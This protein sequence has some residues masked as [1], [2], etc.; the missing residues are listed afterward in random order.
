M[1]V[2]FDP[3][4]ERQSSTRARGTSNAASREYLTPSKSSDTNA[5]PWLDRP[6]PPPSRSPERHS[7]GVAYQDRRREYPQD[8]GDSAKDVSGKT[9]QLAE[10]VKCQDD[11]NANNKDA[12]TSSS[13]PIVWDAG[14]Y[15]PSIDSSPLFPSSPDNDFASTGDDSLESRLHTVDTSSGT[16]QQSLPKHADGSIFSS[17]PRG[18]EPLPEGTVRE[19]PTVTRDNSLNTLQRNTPGEYGRSVSPT[20]ALQPWKPSYAADDDAKATAANMLDDSSAGLSGEHFLQRVSNSVKHARSLSDKTPRDHRLQRVPVNGSQA[21]SPRSETDRLREEVVWL[22]SELAT[23]RQR[24]KERDQRIAA[25]ETALNASADIKQANTELDEKRSTMVILD[26]QREIVL[27]ELGILSDHAGP[28]S[29]GRGERADSGV[30]DL[31]RITDPV[32]R[33]FADSIN[34]LEQSYAPQIEELVRKR[35]E[36]SEELANVNR[37]KDRSLREFDQLTSKNAQLAELNNELVHQIQ[38]LYKVNS[39]AAAGSSTGLGIYSHSKEKSGDVMK[40]YMNDLGL[41]PA[42]GTEDMD[43]T[44]VP[45]SQVVSLRKGQPRKFNWKRGGQKAKGVT[46]GI[47]DAFMSSEPKDMTVPSYGSSTTTLQEASPSGLYRA[48]PVQDPSRQGFALFGN[49]RSRQGP[50]P[51]PNG[52]AATDLPPNGRFLSS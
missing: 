20:P 9:Q 27:R 45:G 49:Q 52:G 36:A 44:I 42:N 29:R 39:S 48:Q 41:S 13:V 28:E 51:Y 40:P 26:A 10:L 14:G 22:R 47:K 33:E 3:N 30:L 38:E 15:L 1:S 19:R 23:E 7:P 2:A 17:R 46:K 4:E 18:D 11:F 35:N 50:K 5:S 31:H 34:R 24:V 8:N 25:I 21:A 16:Q 37:L 32:L 6:P 12:G 43:A